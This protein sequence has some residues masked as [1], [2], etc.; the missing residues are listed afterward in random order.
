M[1]YEV[2]NMNAMISRCKY[3]FVFR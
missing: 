1:K 3:L 2:G